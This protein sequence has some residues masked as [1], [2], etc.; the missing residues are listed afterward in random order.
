MTAVHIEEPPAPPDGPRNRGTRLLKR[1]HALRVATLRR[2]GGRV[3]TVLAA[4][5]VFVALVI[6]RELAM[7]TPWALLR[8]PVE[9]IVGVVLVLALPRRLRSWVAGACG[10]VLGVLL[11]LKALDVGFLSVLGRPFDPVLDWVLLDNAREFLHGS[12]GPTGAIGATVAAVL[13]AVLAVALMALAA[14]RLS[15]VVGR[16]R[17]GA[18]RAAA[19]LSVVWL[20]AFA[21]SLQIVEPVPVASR[22]A[23]ALAYEKA[24]QV[25]VSL[26]DEREFAAQAASDSL[27]PAAV[28]AQEEMLAGLRG[29]DVLLTFIE[30]YGRNAVE[31]PRYA[32]QVDA[33]LQAGMARL[34]AGGYAARS[35]WLTSPVS[36]GSS[37]LAHATLVSG[38]RIDNQ[39]RYRSLVSS[40]R[41]TLSKAFQSSGWETAN[42]MPG[43]DRAWPEAAYFGFDRVHDGPGLGYQGLDFAWSPMPD[44]YALAQ[45]QRREHGRTDRGPLMAQ[46]E[47]TSSHV[48]WWPYPKLVDWDAIGDGSIFRAQVEGGEPPEKIWKNDDRMREAYRDSTVYSL[49][50]VLS[51]VERYGDDRLVMVFL[52]DHQPASIITGE[53]PSHDVPIT[54]VTRDRAVL[55]RIADW[56]WAEGLKPGPQTPVWP[57]DAFRD[58][59]MSAFGAPPTPR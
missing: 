42:V 59:F 32:P 48:P 37:W 43:T 30:S 38:L 5:V 23:A 19:V 27:A 58:R 7:I 21:L 16:Y 12:F 28:A 47:L 49:E 31:D 8:I 57:M 14:R 36:G 54:I 13:L 44:Q 34:A 53:N 46:L 17:S 51:Y 10:A 52:G 33:T 56:R 50:T 4:L 24:K 40:D 18:T 39:Q 6:P 26:R 3:L 15:R 55:D 2:V 35:G 20:A 45:F 41:L 1:L 22:S 29:K 11:I 25:P 9:A